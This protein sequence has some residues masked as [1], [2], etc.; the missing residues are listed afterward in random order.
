MILI[1]QSKNQTPHGHWIA[2]NDSLLVLA[3]RIVHDILTGHCYLHFS[4]IGSVAKLLQDIP[5]VIRSRIQFQRT[6]VTAHFNNGIRILGC[7]F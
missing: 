2:I 3:V 6:G 5:A 1:K 4:G 7:H